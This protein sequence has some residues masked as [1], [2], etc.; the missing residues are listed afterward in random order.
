MEQLSD[1][2]ADRVGRAAYYGGTDCV[3]G[4]GGVIA[5][6]KL[7]PERRAYYVGIAACV[8]TEDANLRGVEIVP[9]SESRSES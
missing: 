6:E 4:R 3:D 8:L 2:E 1:D 9:R 7:T 5:W